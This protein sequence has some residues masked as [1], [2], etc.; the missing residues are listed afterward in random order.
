[1]IEQRWYYSENLKP[2]GPLSFQEI[3]SLI[4]EGEVVEGQLIC[5]ER[6]GVW[7]PVREWKEFESAL[8]GKPLSNGS[9]IALPDQL[10][11]NKM[12]STE[13]ELFQAP[14]YSPDESHKEWII[15]VPSADGKVVLQE[16]PYSRKQLLFGLQNQS[17]SPMQYVW[18]PGLGEWVRLGDHPEFK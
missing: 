9:E 17:I 13:H 14:Q 18:K 1:M 6:E 2:I 5:S 4:F 12:S 15:L 3:Q 10:V 7:K 11:T 16:G 8:L